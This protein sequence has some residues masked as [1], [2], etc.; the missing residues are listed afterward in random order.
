MKLE[1]S[2]QNIEF[3]INVEI[4]KNMY[5]AKEGQPVCQVTNMYVEEYEFEIIHS[6]EYLD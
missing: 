6:F 4:I 5:V 3:L 1:Q 2:K